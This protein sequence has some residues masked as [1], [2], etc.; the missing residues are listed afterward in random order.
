MMSAYQSRQNTRQT[1]I[2]Y[3]TMG[4]VNVSLLAIGLLTDM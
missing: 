1:R 3:G 4:Y 2:L